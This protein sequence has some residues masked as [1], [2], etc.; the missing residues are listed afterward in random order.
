MADWRMEKCKQCR[1]TRFFHMGLAWACTH[2]DRRTYD[3]L[4]GCAGFRGKYD[5][6]QSDDHD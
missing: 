5:G 4:C 1:H 6:E 2:E 3:G